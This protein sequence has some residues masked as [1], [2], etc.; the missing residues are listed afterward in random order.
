MFFLMGIGI[1]NCKNVDVRLSQ[2]ISSSWTIPSTPLRAE[3]LDRIQY[4]PTQQV[5]LTQLK[6][7]M[8]NANLRKMAAERLK[9]NL[10]RDEQR[11]DIQ[12]NRDQIA[13]EQERQRQR[14]EMNSNLNADQTSTNSNGQTTTGSG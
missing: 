7:R 2:S 3:D 6:Q 14:A 12:R 9:P 11:E 8:E 1:T 13:K 4:R 10:R 5:D